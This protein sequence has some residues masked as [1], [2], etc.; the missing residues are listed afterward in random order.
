MCVKMMYNMT[1]FIKNVFQKK[2]KRM[3]SKIKWH[4]STIQKLQLR[5]HQPNCT[6]H[7][8]SW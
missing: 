4:I 3:Y 6:V 2:K 8:M 7:T 5:L 1:T